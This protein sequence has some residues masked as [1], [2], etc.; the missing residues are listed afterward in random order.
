MKP[1]PPVIRTVSPSAP[2]EEIGTAPSAP[3][4]NIY[5]CELPTLPRLKHQL[6]A[7]PAG[8]PRRLTKCVAERLSDEELDE[9]EREFRRLRELARLRPPFTVVRSREKAA[10]QQSSSPEA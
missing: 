4:N 5:R 2:P 6:P 10:T 3:S 7:A 8:A 9:L 1:A